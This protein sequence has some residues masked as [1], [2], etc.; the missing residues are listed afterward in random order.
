MNPDLR[1]SFRTVGEWVDR[2]SMA[3][4]WSALVAVFVWSGALALVGKYPAGRPIAQALPLSTDVVMV[5][6]GITKLVI[7]VGLIVPFLM[8]L[9][10]WLSVAHM[11]VVAIPLITYPAA[12]FLRV[13]YAPS[14][15]GVYILKD[16]VL[17]SGVV[18]I[19]DARSHS[20]EGPDAPEG[21]VVERGRITPWIRSVLER[22]R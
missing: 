5:A 16:W 12:T 13:P 7:G 8:R 20:V 10:L 18:V 15:E 19:N 9:A 2:Y 1:R 21:S 22:L 14:F 6:F 17:L 3:L 11:V 4:L